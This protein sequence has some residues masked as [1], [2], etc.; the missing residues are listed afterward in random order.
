MNASSNSLGDSSQQYGAVRLISSAFLLLCLV[1]SLTSW[2]CSGIHFQ[3][4]VHFHCF[5][6]FGDEFIAGYV[7]FLFELLHC[8]CFRIPCYLGLRMR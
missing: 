3:C 1:S 5:A 6:V 2:V 7:I 8:G 4:S